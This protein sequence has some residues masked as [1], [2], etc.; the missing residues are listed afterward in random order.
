[1]RYQPEARERVQSVREM[2]RQ[3]REER[4]LTR[5]ELAAAASSDRNTITWKDVECLEDRAARLPPAE[6]LRPVTDALGLDW[7]EVLRRAGYW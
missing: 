1:M 5:T 2:I 6:I 4:G 7:I 3:R